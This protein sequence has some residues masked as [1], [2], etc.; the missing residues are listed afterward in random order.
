MDVQFARTN[1][2]KGTRP[3]IVTNNPKETLEQLNSEREPLYEKIA[4]LIY[5]TDE[6]H[7]MQIA[8]QILDDILSRST[9]D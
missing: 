4:D 6:L 9:T 7:P 8:K 5:P 1:R 3:M 2:S